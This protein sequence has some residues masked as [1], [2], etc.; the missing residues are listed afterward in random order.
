MP[1]PTPP[2]YGWM[3]CDGRL[4]SIS[5]YQVLFAVIGINYGGDG[6][7]NFAL[8]DLRGR[9]P[10]GYGQ[11]LSSYSIGLQSGEETVQL[12]QTEMP[13]HTHPLS[14][15]AMGYAK[16][17]T[18]FKA[19]PTAGVSWLSRY[20]DTTNTPVVSLLAYTPTPPATGPTNPVNMASTSV[21]ATGPGGAH[22]NRQP[23]PGHTILHQ[24]RSRGFPCESISYWRHS[25]APLTAHLNLVF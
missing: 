22:E 14:T 11:G 15:L 23:F 6:Q 18:A 4:L 20:F 8:P 12:D 3:D 5:Q 13:S 2:P 7:T 9:I 17:P 19:T 1:L 10:L 21:T 16:G 25:N 24:L